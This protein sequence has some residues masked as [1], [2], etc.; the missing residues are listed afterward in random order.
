MT[1]FEIVL[2]SLI[3][4]DMLFIDKIIDQLKSPDNYIYDQLSSIMDECLE[5]I[6]KQSSILDDYRK[7][8]ENM[9]EADRI[10]KTRD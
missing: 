8:M 6:K 3:K 9:R 5:H 7:N 2:L 1:E 4:Q 10:F